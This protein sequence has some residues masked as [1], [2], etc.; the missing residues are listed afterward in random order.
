MSV[1][2]WLATHGTDRPICPH[3]EHEHE[4]A[5]ELNDGEEGDWEQDC[6]SCGETFTCS[7]VVHITFSTTKEPLL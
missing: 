6:H 4:D 5:W 7:R 1:P 3:C 2:D